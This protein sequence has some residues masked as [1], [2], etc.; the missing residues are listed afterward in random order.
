MT[1]NLNSFFELNQKSEEIVRRAKVIGQIFW[2][3]E[4]RETL[5]LSTK[6]YSKVFFFCNIEGYE[7]PSDVGNRGMMMTFFREVT[8]KATGFS[9]HEVDAKSFN[10]A[11]SILFGNPNHYFQTLFRVY[12]HDLNYGD[13]LKHFL[14]RVPQISWE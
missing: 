10:Q 13:V 12:E 9:H 3:A 2:W 14:P 1:M 4:S 8:K 5:K 7:S 11:C 6:G